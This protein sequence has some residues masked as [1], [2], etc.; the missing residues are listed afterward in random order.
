M[1]VSSVSQQPLLKCFTLPPQKTQRYTERWRE[2]EN[3]TAMV[4]KREEELEKEVTVYVWG[5]C[6]GDWE[7]RGMNWSGVNLCSHRGPVTWQILS[8][9]YKGVPKLGQL[10]R[11]ICAI[12]TKCWYVL[13][14]GSADLL[15]W[16]LML[17]E[18]LI[19]ILQ[20]MVAGAGKLAW[21]H[22][23]MPYWDF[24]IIANFV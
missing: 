16:K 4:N 14:R 9:L 17:T 6:L 19:C 20:M 11:L 10:L 2:W 18:G 7:L 13:L 3:K 21:N 22:A 15:K 5:V 23:C 1:S 24:D 8:H 12:S